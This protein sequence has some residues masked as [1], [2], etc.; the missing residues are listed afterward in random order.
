MA[1]KRVGVAQDEARY[2]KL[3]SMSPQHQDVGTLEGQQIHD[4]VFAKM[5]MSGY[6]QAGRGE[7]V[8]LVLRPDQ[9]AGD[10]EAIK[11]ELNR[12][13]Y[14]EAAMRYFDFEKPPELDG[15]NEVIGVEQASTWVPAAYG[16]DAY[17]RA[18]QKE[19]RT[20]IPPPH[21]DISKIR[22]R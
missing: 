11:T 13:K 16:I 9:V 19:S 21:T 15:G 10:Q 12:I 7:A 8:I 20:R 17:K 14:Y 4:C 1:Y 5:H 3:D 18:A 6:G 2:C 22:M